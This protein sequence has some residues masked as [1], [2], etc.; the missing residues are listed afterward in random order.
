MCFLVVMLLWQNMGVACLIFIS[1]LRNKPSLCEQ[2]YKSTISSCHCISNSFLY[3][4]CVFFIL[5]MS[6]WSKDGMMTHKVGSMSPSWRKEAIRHDW[7]R[8]SYVLVSV[9]RVLVPKMSH[10]HL[11][12]NYASEKVTLTNNNSNGVIPSQWGYKREDLRQTLP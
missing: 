2:C 6:S 4:E 3:F 12:N 10:N 1:S 11:R 9:Q 7:T 8:I 5:L